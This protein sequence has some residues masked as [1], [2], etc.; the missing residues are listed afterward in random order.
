MDILRFITAGSVDDG[1][2]TLIGRLLYDSKSILQDQLEVLEKHSKNKNEDGVDLAL[3]TD[4]L[5]AEREQGITIDVA[6]RYFSTAKRK[7][8]IADAPGHVQYTRNMIT[9]ASNSDLMVILI[10]AR[11]GVI[12]QTRRHSIIASLLQLKKVAVAI[13]KMD[14]VDYSEE[15]FENIKSEYSKIAENL[16]LNDVSYFPISAL[17]GDNIVSKSSRTDWYEGNSLLEYLEEVTINE[18]KNN[19]SRFQVQYVIRPQTEEL[20]DYRGYAGQILSGK[21]TKG[22]KIHILPASLATE[23]TKIEINGIEKEEAFEGQPAV[24][25]LAHDV[26]ISRGDIFATEEHIPAVE[27]DLEILLCWLDQKPLQP[28]N[29]YLLQQNSRLI[30]AVV[31]EVDYKINVN[32]LIRE[33]A[34]G[35]IKLNEIVKVTLRTAQP[36]VYDSFT[37]NKTTGSAIL[38]DETSNSTV[39][40]CII[41]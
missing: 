37:N 33:Q 32:T 18:E 38:V 34:D 36:L 6:Y 3:L 24:I 16:G 40:A 12:E 28:G 5:R 9:G 11:K 20:H 1:K 41:Q 4:G 10:D 29:K 14:M 7:F 23:I 31:K 30:K 35:E 15:V 2:S 26:D 21:F 8:I 27:K 17:K 19:G 25:H 39:A 22:D 13:N